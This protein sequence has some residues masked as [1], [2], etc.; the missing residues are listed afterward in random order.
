[1]PGRR[2]RSVPWAESAVFGPPRLERPVRAIAP[3]ADRRMASPSPGASWI[4]A[5]LVPSYQS[6]C[7]LS[8][9]FNARPR[10]ASGGVRIVVLDHFAHGHQDFA[11]SHIRIAGVRDEHV[12]YQ[13]DVSRVPWETDSH[14]GIEL[15][16]LLD[17]FTRDPRTI[18]EIHAAGQVGFRIK[19]QQRRAQLRRQAG[20]MMQQDLVEENHL[21]GL[22][23]RRKRAAPAEGLQCVPLPPAFDPRRLAGALHYGPVF[24]FEE[25]L[26]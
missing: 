14:A 21:P 13:Q 20:N 10:S 1:M 4:P 15:L 24:G 12:V 18:A 7:R 3:P 23:M 9:L 19:R 16:N 5:R 22:R 25:V 8:E 2:S 6:S 17:R 11:R 26:P